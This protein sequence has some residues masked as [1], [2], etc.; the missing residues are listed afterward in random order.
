VSA[1]RKGDFIKIMKD[2]MELIRDIDDLRK[3]RDRLFYVRKK[4]ETLTAKTHTQ[5]MSKLGT[6]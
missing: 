4:A 1:I 2:N 5:S 3:E 6:A